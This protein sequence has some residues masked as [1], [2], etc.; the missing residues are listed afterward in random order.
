MENMVFVKDLVLPS[1]LLEAAD[2]AVKEG[3]VISRS[4]LIAR[5]LRR[6]LA[7][8]KRPEIDA[9]LAEMLKDPEYHT[10]V[11]QM[12][13]EF[14]TAAFSALLFDSQTV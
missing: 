1:E 6:E 8:M 3:K 4:E 12:E 7:A 13:A 10:Q 9:E 11:L 5:A 2:K 14:A